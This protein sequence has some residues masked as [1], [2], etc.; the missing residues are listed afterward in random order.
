MVYHHRFYT[1]FLLKKHPVIAKNDNLKSHLKCIKNQQLNS[2]IYLTAMVL[3]SKLY[4]EAD[5]FRRFIFSMEVLLKKKIIAFLAPFIMTVPVLA[6]QA[7]VDVD[8]S[9]RQAITISNV[10][11]LE[12]GTLEYDTSDN[13]GTISMSTSGTINVGSTG[14]VAS[15]SSG[16]ASLDIAANSGENIIV[17][18]SSGATL[19]RLGSPSSTLSISTVSYKFGSTDYNCD[20]N[21]DLMVSSGTDSLSIGVQ[22]VVPNGV[23]AED[24]DYSTSNSGGSPITFTVTYQ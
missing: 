11:D 8:V 20:G 9:L 19:A 15:G 23:S 13:G 4:S 1:P 2:V 17:T 10:T 3:S 18:C 12:F 6:E 14:Y 21:G 7:D 24:G 16:A 5:V 22:L